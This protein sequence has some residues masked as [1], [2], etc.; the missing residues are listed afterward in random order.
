M[1]LKQKNYKLSSPSPIS[2]PTMSLVS[3]ESISI[4]FSS[5]EPVDLPS[6]NNKNNN[7]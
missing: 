1:D 3:S 6:E 7:S 2:S 5:P 4:S